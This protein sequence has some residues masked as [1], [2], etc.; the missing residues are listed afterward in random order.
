MLPK[1]LNIVVVEF[2]DDFTQLESE[3]TAESAQEALE[4]LIGM[5][6]WE[7]ATDDKKRKK[8]DTQFTAL[9]VVVDLKG[10][11]LLEHS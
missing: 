10:T 3:E 4:C 1:L 11:N 8:F 2:F 5:L 9:G 6:G 7:L